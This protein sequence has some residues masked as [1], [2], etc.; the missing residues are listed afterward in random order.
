MSDSSRSRISPAAPL[1]KVSARTPSA[2]T[3]CSTS[4]AKRRVMT[5]V[6][7]VPAPATTSSGP[8]GWVTASRCGALR[9]SSGAG[10]GLG[11]AALWE[12]QSGFRRSVRGNDSAPMPRLRKVDCSAPGIT[13]RGRGRGFEYLDQNGKKITDPDVLDRIGE[14]RIPPAWRELWIW[15][16]PLG[17]L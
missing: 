7:P 5:R 9:P 6:L 16:D 3:P 8:P 11:Y 13:R 15:R 12:P 1:E 14:L 17:H 2:G 4:Q 10:M